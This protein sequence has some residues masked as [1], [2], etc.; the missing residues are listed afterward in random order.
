MRKRRRGS[1]EG[2]GGTELRAERPAFLCGLTS[3]WPAL[4]NSSATVCPS[5]AVNSESVFTFTLASSLDF[6]LRSLF[7]SSGKSSVHFSWTVVVESQS[8][9][10]FF[11]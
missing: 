8:H 7:K 6:T 11:F 2:D 4:H 1:S 5:A 3:C 9:T 10:G